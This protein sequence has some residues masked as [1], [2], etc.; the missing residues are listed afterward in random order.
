MGY[1]EKNNNAIKA[2]TTF[3]IE[4]HVPLRMTVT[5]GNGNE[6]EVLKEELEPGRI[7]VKDRGY[8]SLGLFQE[9]LNNKSSFVCRINDNSVYD[10]IEEYVVGEKLRDTIAFDRKIRL[11][12]NKKTKQMLQEP[13]RLVAV[14]CKPHKKRYHISRGGPE[15]GEVL[16]IATNIL[17]VDADVIALIYKHRWTVEIFFRFFKHILGCRHLISHSENGIE[18]QMYAAIIACMLIALWTGRKP[19]LRTYEMLCWYFTGLADEEELAAHIARL[20]KQD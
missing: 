14:K 3:D 6:K 11:G 7:Y 20:K 16:L 8:A 19:T 2:H 17:D 1:M 15:Q 13:I 5:G 10:I 4:K 12:S 18:L 9:I